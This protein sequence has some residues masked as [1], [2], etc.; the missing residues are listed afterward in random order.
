MIMDMIEHDITLLSVGSFPV[1][2]RDAHP[3]RVT[4][5]MSTFTLFS[6][7]FLTELV[8]VVAKKAWS[9]LG[10]QM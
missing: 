7:S 10:T 4:L 9:D 6:P 8:G 2:G 5:S 3:N 1:N